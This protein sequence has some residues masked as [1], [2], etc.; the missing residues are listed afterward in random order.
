L[1]TKDSA[2]VRATA[3]T[4]SEELAAN[5]DQL[6]LDECRLLWRKTFK[7]SPH[8]HMSVQFMR[9]ALSYEHQCRAFGDLEADIKGALKS[10]S[11]RVLV[12]V[13]PTTSKRAPTN[14]TSLLSPGTHLIR[15]WNGHTY[16]VE[17]TETGFRLDR[18]EFKSLSAIAK[19]I[20]GTQW[21]GPRFFGLHNQ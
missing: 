4:V 17:V 9:R 13:K 2:T 12:G 5:V 18:Q 10:L 20:T 15:E 8:K 3:P 1:R 21:S 19:H 14:P 6:D 11:K 7:H 16:Q